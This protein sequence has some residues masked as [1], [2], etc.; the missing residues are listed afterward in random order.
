MDDRDASAYQ[1]ISTS[2]LTI[3]STTQTTWG[4]CSHDQFKVK[5]GSKMK[6]ISKKLKFTLKAELKSNLKKNGNPYLKAQVT[7]KKHKCKFAVKGC[8]MSKDVTC[9][10]MSHPL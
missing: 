7:K 1:N 4:N 2:L 6:L 10:R 5:R 8:H 3:M 9:L